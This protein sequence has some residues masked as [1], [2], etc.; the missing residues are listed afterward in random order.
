[1]YHGRIFT[2][3]TSACCEKEPGSD[4]R[5]YH[6]FSSVSNTQVSQLENIRSHEI[7][8]HSGNTC[9]HNSKVFAEKKIQ[10]EDEE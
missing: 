4:W 2:S 1:M 9:R 7:Q 3:F 5:S 6:G 8:S 10:R